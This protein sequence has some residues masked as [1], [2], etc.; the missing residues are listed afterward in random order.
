MPFFMGE[1]AIAREWRR[2]FS[3]IFVDFNIFEA[4]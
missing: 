2:G 3:I 4:G 1:L